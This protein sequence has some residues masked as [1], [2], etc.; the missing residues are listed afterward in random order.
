MRDSPNYPFRH[1]VFRQSVFRRFIFRQI[2]I[3]QIVLDPLWPTCLFH[4]HTP[5]PFF[6]TE[7]YITPSRG[8]FYFFA[9]FFNWEGAP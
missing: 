4:I 6:F 9:Y 5:L 3:R 2:I 7:D 8:I 1:V